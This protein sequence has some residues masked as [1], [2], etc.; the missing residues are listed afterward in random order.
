[1]T[2]TK[3]NNYIHMYLVSILFW[4]EINFYK[5]YLSENIL[6]RLLSPLETFNL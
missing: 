5:Y 3:I 2:K 4:M 6:I 1:M